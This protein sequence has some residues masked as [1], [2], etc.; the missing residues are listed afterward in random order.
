[1]IFVTTGTQ[2]PFD[3]LLC[4]IDEIAPDLGKEEIVVQTI[5]GSYVP[6][7]IKVIEYLCSAEYK[8]IMSR[9]RL[10]VSHAGTGTIISAL[11]LKKPII[12]MP[13]R[14][15]LGEHRNEHQLATVNKFE[16]L[17][18]VYAAYDSIQLQDLIRSGNIKCRKELGSNA[19][20]SL[21]HSLKKFILDVCNN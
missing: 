2:L 17:Q 16:E 18:F 13:R 11:M 20:D 14:A 15:S 4:A 9:A 12:V 7:N 19:S 5:K 3:R 10:I 6:H 21:I 1:M 8:N